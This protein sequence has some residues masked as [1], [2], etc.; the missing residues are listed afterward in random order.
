MYIPE[1]IAGYHLD[2]KMQTSTVGKVLKMAVNTRAS[3][4]QH[5]DRDLKYCS[6]EYQ[7]I[8]E[9]QKFTQ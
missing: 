7:G 3:H 8:H 2:K 1:N 5:P 6:T 9:Q 4:I